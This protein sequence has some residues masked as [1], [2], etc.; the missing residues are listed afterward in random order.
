MR[1]C[2][3]VAVKAA[4]KQYRKPETKQTLAKCIAGWVGSQAMPYYPPYNNIMY[5]PLCVPVLPALDSV[6]CR[7]SS[8]YI[9]ITATVQPHE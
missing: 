3:E 5:T 6:A 9:Q 8:L 4:P 1:S 7:L 2:L